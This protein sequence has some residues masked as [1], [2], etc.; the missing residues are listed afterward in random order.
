MC[1][2]CVPFSLV[3]IADVDGGKNQT[4]EES[5]PPTPKEPQ[6]QWRPELNTDQA[7]RG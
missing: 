4:K 3:L 5:A 6:P 7:D 2:E 1:P